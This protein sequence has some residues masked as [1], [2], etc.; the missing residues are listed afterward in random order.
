[1]R[2]HLRPF[3]KEME[4]RAAKKGS[5]GGGA[6]SSAAGSKKAAAASPRKPKAP[7]A[8]QMTLSFSGKL[9]APAAAPAAA[10]A[11]A[12]AGDG[13]DSD[14]AAAAM[15]AP[16]PSS[17]SKHPDNL[18]KSYRELCDEA[19]CVFTIFRSFLCPFL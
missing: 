6:S 18:F 13:D 19:C 8:G 11:A 1:M 7:L 15:S 5:G 12:A 10:A 3:L 9:N 16:L 17:D 4:E 14:K 2:E